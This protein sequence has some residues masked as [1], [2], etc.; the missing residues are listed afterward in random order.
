MRIDV[1]RSFEK[2]ISKLNDK[3]LARKVLA[4]IQ[5][6]ETCDSLADVPNL[7][8]LNAKGNYY[9]IRVGDYRM[10]LKL[11]KNVIVLLRFLDRKAM[12]KYFP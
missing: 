5:S 8:K 12:Y 4:L 10:G 3:S 11:E 2:D 1:Q 6:L 7:K 9:R